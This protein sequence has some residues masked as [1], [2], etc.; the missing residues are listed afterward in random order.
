MVYSE[1]TVSESTTFQILLQQSTQIIYVSFAKSKFSL[2]LFFAVVSRAGS[3][4]IFS[5]VLSSIEVETKPTLNSDI[6]FLT[7]F[8][9]ARIVS[10]NF[11][12]LTTA[13]KLSQHFATLNDEHRI[14][15]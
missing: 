3:S 1:V 12:D 5:H 7:N 8:N 10:A 4:Y 13:L 14:P 9:K 11:A 6:H 15:T 2:E